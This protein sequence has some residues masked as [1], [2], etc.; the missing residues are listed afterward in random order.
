[1][2][3]RFRFGVIMKLPLAGRTW[4][5]SAKHVEDLGFSTLVVPDHFDD[6]LAVG[7][8]LADVAEAPTTLRLGAL[9]YGTDYRHPGMTAKEVA[10]L[11]SLSHGRVELGLGAGWTLIDYDEEVR[12]YGRPGVR[13]EHKPDATDIA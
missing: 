11:D 5:Q 6:Q 7:L 8:A 12:H 10:T 2:T 1:M 4:A 9:V 13:T 3:H